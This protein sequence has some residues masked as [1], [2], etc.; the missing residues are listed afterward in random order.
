VYGLLARHFAEADEPERAVEYLLKAGDAARGVYAEEEAIELYRRALG[1]LDRMDDDARARQTLLKIALTHHLA[2]D[3]RAANDAFT[4]A[5]ARPAP[6]P[7]RMEPR[8]R[9]TWAVPTAW[10]RAAAPGHSLSEPAFEVARNLFRGLV[11]IGRDF[12][13]EP[14]I[15]ERFTVSDDGLSYRFSLRADARWS[16]GRPVTPDDF[17]FTYRQMVEDG[18]ATAS[19]LDGVSASAVDERT[20]EIRLREPRNDFLYMLSQPPFFPW[21]RHIYEREGRDW[22]RAVPLVGNGPFAL[23]SRE[24]DRIV[25]SAAPSW[26]GVRGNVREVTLELEASP[27]AAA[28]RW[29]RGEY[30]VLHDVLTPRAVDD[31]ETTV[32]RSPGMWTWYLGFN[33][34]AMPLSDPRVRRALAHAVDRR[35]PAELLRATAAPTGG[36]VPPTIQGHSPR[37]APAFDPERARALLT[38]AGFADGRGL[39]EV[40]LACLDL[41]EDAASE[42]AAQFEAIGVRVRLLAT[43][44]D[45]DLDAAIEDGAH[46]YFWAWGGEYP[47]TG[48]GF[49]EPV[50]SE[51]PTLYRNGELEDLLAHA[52]SLRDQDQRLRMYR[53][54]E[55]VWIGE[56]AAV[57][58]LAYGDLLLWTRPWITGMWV[59]ATEIST[60]AHAVVRRPILA[61]KES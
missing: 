35:G 55:R 16:D 17:A 28:E 1:F 38:D 14:E 59:N 47:D 34:T 32:L 6:L 3:F 54:F 11:A 26:Q 7:P 56:Q 18:V 45:P 33:A 50:M 53:E 27:A 36:L 2:F 13:I 4:Q 49:L 30:D 51:Y 61:S 23:T 44:S 48:R 46:V 8:E 15:A 58:P 5:L 21:P 10:D 52:A 60:F 12:D 39:D 19:W 25:I 37:V 20:L 9:I 57:V 43:A 42:V 31:E 40:V 41:W 24:E 29:R 22:Q